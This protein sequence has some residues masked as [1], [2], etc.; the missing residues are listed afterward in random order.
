MTIHIIHPRLKLQGMA[1]QSPF[2]EPL[3]PAGL[4]V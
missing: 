3:W 4:L 2:G 1:S